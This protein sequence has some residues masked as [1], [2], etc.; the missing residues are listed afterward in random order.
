VLL[1]AALDGCGIVHLATW[2]VS[3]ALR[4]GSLVRLLKGYEEGEG[5]AAGPSI[6]V[7]RLPG[8]SH[9]QRARLFLN[10]L[11]E[12]VGKSPYWDRALDAP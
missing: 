7:V 6:Y 3:D 2:M 1:Q 5:A 12:H 8:R 4:E 9:A 10:H 11:L